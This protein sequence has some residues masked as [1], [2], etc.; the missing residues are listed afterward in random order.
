MQRL[1]TFCEVQISS[2][3]LQ[4]HVRCYFRANTPEISTLDA[5]YTMKAKLANYM[6]EQLRHK[7]QMTTIFDLKPSLDQLRQLMKYNPFRSEE[8]RLVLER[9][10]RLATLIRSHFVRGAAPTITQLNV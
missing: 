9:G 1:K 7:Q 4:Q 8:Q 3:T 5:T 2:N 6:S 10:D